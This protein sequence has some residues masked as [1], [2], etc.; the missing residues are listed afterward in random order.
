MTALPLLS[1]LVVTLPYEQSPSAAYVAQATSISQNDILTEINR[2]RSDPVAYADRLETIRA[3]YDGTILRWPGQRPIQTQ[4]GTAALDAAITNLR[5]TAPLPPLTLAH[6]LSQ[7]AQDHAQDLSLSGR[8]SSRGSNG[9]TGEDRIQRYGSYEGSFKELVFEGPNEP[10][11]LVAALVIDDGNYQ[12]S[13]Q[14]TLLRNNFEYIGINCKPGSRLALCVTNFADT[15]TE[16]ESSS[17]VSWAANTDNLS[18]LAADFIAETNKVRRN[19]AQYAKKLEALRPY[20]DGTLLKVPGQPAV[21]T[22]EGVA[23][24]DEAIA[25][26]KVAKPVAALDYSDGLSLAAAD[27]A[28][29]LS[30]RNAVGHYG[31]DGR[32]HMERVSRYGA[33]PPGNRAGENISFGAPTLAEWHVIQLLVDDNVPGR[34]HRR[35]MLNDRYQLTGTACAHHD[36][37]QIVCVAVYA[38]DY[39]ER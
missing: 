37:F 8:F 34:G 4:E 22:T 14:E 16:I 11:A 25:V 6:G 26:L 32:T 2:L 9:S 31:A 19:P 28:Q 13:Y 1:S 27:H 10:A 3:Y 23:A 7:A 33:V 20:Y 18:T 21:E 36:T 5:Q 12:R 15:Y 30:V 17:P 29:D 35:T 24:L 38:S 39:E